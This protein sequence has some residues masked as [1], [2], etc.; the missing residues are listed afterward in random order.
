MKIRTGFVSNSSSS[1]FIIAFKGDVKQLKVRLDEVFKLP[2]S[3][4]LKELVGDV[5]KT[6]IKSLEEE[7]QSGIKSMD[8]F[9]SYQSEEY[10]NDIN[11]IDKEQLDLIQKG[12]TL[13]PG[14]FSSEEW[15]IEATLCKTKID[16]VSD[17]LIIKAEGGY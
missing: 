7:Y 17:D 2:D 9:L 6:I 3:Y 5:S 10:G 16:Y 12:F 15:G 1:S 11:D 13:F 14:S 8:D 4:P